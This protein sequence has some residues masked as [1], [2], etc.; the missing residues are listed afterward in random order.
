MEAQTQ[1]IRPRVERA[2]LLLLA[3]AVALLFAAFTVIAL[4]S[5]VSTCSIDPTFYANEIGRASC[6]ERV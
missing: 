3:A 6:R 5:L 2:A 4:S 1:I